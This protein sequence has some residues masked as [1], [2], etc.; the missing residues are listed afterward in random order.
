LK[1]PGDEAQQVRLRGAYEEL[2]GHQLQAV[3]DMAPPSGGVEKERDDSSAETSNQG[4]VQFR[5]HRAED[6][7]GMARLSAE[8]SQKTGEA[9][10]CSF[11]CLKA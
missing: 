5:R 1:R 9:G 8:V 11:Q 3:L 4:R 10:G 2:R 7:G 6:E